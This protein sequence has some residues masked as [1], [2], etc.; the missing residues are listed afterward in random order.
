MIFLLFNFDPDADP[1]PGSDLQKVD[2]DSASIFSEI[3]WF[4]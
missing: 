2:P 4:F 1:D 3:Y